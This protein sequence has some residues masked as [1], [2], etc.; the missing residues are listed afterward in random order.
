MNVY[1]LDDEEHYDKFRTPDT[2]FAEDKVPTPGTPY[3]KRARLY[4]EAREEKDKS[5]R[6]R[7]LETYEADAETTDEEV[8]CKVPSLVDICVTYVRG[9]IWD[10]LLQRKYDELE[11]PEAAIYPKLSV[12]PSRD[13]WVSETA[14]Q[15]IGLPTE[16]YELVAGSTM[17]T[18]KVCKTS[19]WPVG[20]WHKDCLDGRIDLLG[21][22]RTD[23]WRRVVPDDPFACSNCLRG[24]KAPGFNEHFVM[25]MIGE[26]DAYEWD[27]LR[28]GK[29]VFDG[30]WRRYVV[31]IACCEACR[32][33]LKEAHIC[34]PWTVLG[35][36]KVR[37]LFDRGH[38]EDVFNFC[39]SD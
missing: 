13:D 39:L 18:P 27:E 6:Q 3:V 14:R 2:S 32:V 4:L 19:F 17:A 35:I 25:R 24:T 15:L 10:T 31:M 34:R 28:P 11:E 37:Q 26:E 8:A 7:V 9:V 30:V 38:Y 1:D 16:V 21:I 23:N 33:Q 29:K 12:L 20:E 5:Y 36:H 22:A